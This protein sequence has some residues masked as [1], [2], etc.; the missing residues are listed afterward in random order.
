MIQVSLYFLFT[1]LVSEYGFRFR[2]SAI[3]CLRGPWRWRR[4][5]IRLALWASVWLLTPRAS[6]E[7]GCLLCFLGTAAFGETAAWLLHRLIKIDVAKQRPHGSPL[8]HLLPVGA[9]LV[10]LVTLFL[11]KSFRVVEI[12]PLLRCPA[13]VP[14]A[15]AASAA[16]FAWS[17][18]LTVSVVETV[19]P[20]EIQTADG[21]RLGA[22]E[23]IGLLERLLV[24]FLVLNGGLTSVGFVI[25]A[26][27]AA[28]F[29]K[30]KEPEFA[31][32]F[33]IGTLCSV[34]SATVSGMLVAVI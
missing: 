3:T 6:F 1:L 21:R 14:A 26:K 19:R 9:S 32:Y 13:V 33:L 15:L 2:E 8:T 12:V 7:W 11:L 30:F 25:A 34:G 28:R 16:L 10:P 24:F 31:E 27:S 20:G 4:T 18:L 5:A 29:P 22:G 23:I 17:T